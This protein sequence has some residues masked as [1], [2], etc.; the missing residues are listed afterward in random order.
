MSQLFARIIWKE[1]KLPE[2]ITVRDS[3]RDPQE[4]R[5]FPNFC[6]IKVPPKNAGTPSHAP[7]HQGKW[8]AAKLL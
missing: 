6:Y 5:C 3:D 4:E 1:V 7:C 8:P 2:G